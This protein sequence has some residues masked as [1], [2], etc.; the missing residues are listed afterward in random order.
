[1]YPFH[2]S[3]RPGNSVPSGLT[4]VRKDLWQER[5]CRPDY[6]SGRRTRPNQL[7]KH[8]RYTIRQERSGPDVAIF[9]CTRR[10]RTSRATSALS[11]STNA[12]MSAPCGPARMR[13][14][15]TLP[16]VSARSRSRRV[17]G[18]MVVVGVR[19]AM[20]RCATLT[21]RSSRTPSRSPLPAHFCSRSRWPRSLH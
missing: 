12:R 16:S 18:S 9:C 13:M 14:C 20:R 6:P 10:R 19:G 4:I 2:S 11:L 21:P 17:D 8:D 1:M 7:T 3:R 5:R 15:S